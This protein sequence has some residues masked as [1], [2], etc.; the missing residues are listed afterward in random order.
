[1][2]GPEDERIAHLVT[3]TI[4]SL[5]LFLVHEV[6]SLLNILL[7]SF[8]QSR[9]SP[10]AP[11]AYAPGFCPFR[12]DSIFWKVTEAQSF[13]VP[14]RGGN[15]VTWSANDRFQR[16]TLIMR[17]TDFEVTSFVK[18]LWRFNMKYYYMT[19]T[20]RGGVFFC[21]PS[22]RHHS[23][24][25]QLIPSPLLFWWLSWKFDWSMIKVKVDC[26]APHIIIIIGSGAGEINEWERE[27][28]RRRWGSIGK[29]RWGGESSK[30]NFEYFSLLQN[31]N[32]MP[33]PHSWSKLRRYPSELVTFTC[34]RHLVHVCC[35]RKNAWKIILDH[36]WPDVFTSPS[37][38][39]SPPCSLWS[40][41]HPSFP[42]SFLSSAFQ[43]FSDIRM[44][45][46]DHRNRRFSL[47]DN[48]RR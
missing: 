6:F 30:N 20:K 14:T 37:F 17:R 13:S 12:L 41:V 45:G 34:R 8:R 27:R 47:S 48:F 11:S 33:L 35:E 40:S 23:L 39:P 44:I 38:L 1:M 4:R 46:E 24:L 43:R 28:R 21:W 7:L 16:W 18:L 32:C 10:I 26:F 3:K 29:G 5:N 2:V 15:H 9:P 31:L 22:S 42:P 19:I 25:D 36:R